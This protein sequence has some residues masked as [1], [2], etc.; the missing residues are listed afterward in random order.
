MDGYLD[1][2]IHKAE[3]WVLFE[4]IN[5]YAIDFLEIECDSLLLVDAISEMKP[6][7][8]PIRRALFVEFQRLEAEASME[9]GNEHRRCY[10][11]GFFGVLGLWPVVL[12]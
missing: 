11:L 2:R 1:S 3:A 10:K 8:V 7:V 6:H 12:I 4:G 9:G 5:K